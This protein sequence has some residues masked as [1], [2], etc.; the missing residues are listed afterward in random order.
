MTLI[1]SLH[2]MQAAV[3]S[4]KMRI[5]HK[6]D[7]FIEGYRRVEVGDRQ[8]YENHFG[9]GG[10]SNLFEGDNLVRCLPLDEWGI[11]IS[12]CTETIFCSFGRRTAPAN[13]L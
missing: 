2:T 8:V 9:H 1:A 10:F 6:T 13:V 3:S 12:T 5:V 7:G 4:G 11:A